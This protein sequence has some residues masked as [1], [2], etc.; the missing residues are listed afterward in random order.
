MFK[1]LF[2]LFGGEKQKFSRVELFFLSK[3]NEPTN[4]AEVS[5]YVKATLRQDPAKVVQKY[6]GGGL[7]ESAT[8]L[9]SLLASAKQATLKQALKDAGLKVS[10]KKGRS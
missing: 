2:S 10:G 6:L 5:G 4:P 1:S 7:I 3:F 9:S 8:E